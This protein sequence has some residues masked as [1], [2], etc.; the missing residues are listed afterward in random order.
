M[1]KLLQSVTE[2]Y[3]KVRQVLESVTDCYKT[4]RQLFTNCDCYKKVRGN[5]DPPSPI[6]RLDCYRNDSRATTFYYW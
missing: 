6:P 1:K 4:V 2:I 3:Y 5:T